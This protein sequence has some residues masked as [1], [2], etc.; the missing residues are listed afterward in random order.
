MP[1][2]Q[3]TFRGRFIDRVNVPA[4][5]KK[6][7]FGGVGGVGGATEHSFDTSDDHTAARK[8]DQLGVGGGGDFLREDVVECRCRSRN[9]G[10]LLRTRTT[11]QISFT[12]ALAW[13][14]YA[15]KGL[16]LPPALLPHG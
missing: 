15:R 4:A 16:D 12:T 6:D 5:H 10:A 7:A 13:A 11:S 2:L 8:Q 1:V 14:T 9:D 3:K